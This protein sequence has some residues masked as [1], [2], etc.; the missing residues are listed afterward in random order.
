VQVW[1]NQV[2]AEIPQP[3]EMEVELFVLEVDGSGLAVGQPADLVVESRPEARFHGVV[4]FVDQLAK[5]LQSWL[6]VRYFATVVALDRTDRAVMKPG[7]RVRAELVLDRQ[8]AITVPR[9]AVFDRAGKTVV[10]RRDARGFAPVTVALGAATP[11]R[12][13][14]ASGIAEG[15]VIAE[16]DP[17]RPLDLEIGSEPGSGTAAPP[18]KGAP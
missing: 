14:I 12:I 8:E 9:Q 17:T 11:G 18:A 7:Q 6:P 5:P 1:N 16:R 4:R 2:L 13:A 10:Y 3:G 15:D